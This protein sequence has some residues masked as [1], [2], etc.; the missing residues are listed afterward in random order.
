[1]N[2]VL[3]PPGAFGTTIGYV[4]SRFSLGENIEKV[5][6]TK[7]ISPD[8]SMHLAYGDINKRPG[9]WAFQSQLE[10]FFNGETDQHIKISTPIYPNPDLHANEIINLFEKHRPTDK[11]VFLYIKDLYYSELNMIIQY[12]KIA[13]GVLN[14]SLK[15]FCGKNE[16][17]I[18]QWNSNYT[19]WTQMQSWEL[20]EWLS[21]F[22][23][24]WVSEWIE[25]KNYVPSHWL[26]I[27]TEEILN[28][29][30]NTFIKVCEYCNGYNESTYE[31]LK[32]FSEVWRSKQQYLIDEY[33]LV[34]DIVKNSINKTNFDWVP[35][36]IISES[37]I[38]Q[39]LRSHG[40]EIKCHNLNSFP[41][42]SIHLHHLMEKI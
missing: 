3:F 1:M 20:R 27:S 10:N 41:T 31:E 30:F 2:H 21:L 22:Y 5:C 11:Y 12:Y 18:K 4:L 19:H 26:V 32:Y 24:D 35:L 13:H 29:T 34:N 23:I 8:G 42:N 36:N 7:L 37:I 28:D 33:K 39:Q 14:E 17:N 38:Q 40:Y 9:H 15:I 6:P 25:A 16:H